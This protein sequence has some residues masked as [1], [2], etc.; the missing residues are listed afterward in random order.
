[1]HFF[2]AVTIFLEESSIPLSYLNKNSYPSCSQGLSKTKIW[3]PD[4]RIETDRQLMYAMLI[5]SVWQT[6]R[7]IMLQY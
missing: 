1:M 4:I 3:A 7:T 6:N 5:F 2:D